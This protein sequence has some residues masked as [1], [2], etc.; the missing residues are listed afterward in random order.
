V[1]LLLFNKILYFK[2]MKF[3]PLI[4]A[5]FLA[6]SPGSVFAASDQV[7]EAEGTENS[8]SPIKEIMP[9][10][11]QYLTPAKKFLDT[12][13]RALKN[14]MNETLSDPGRPTTPKVSI[15]LPPPALKAPPTT[16]PMLVQPE[17][18][19]KEEQ[20]PA[21][22][23]PEPKAAVEPSTQT[24]VNEKVIEDVRAEVN[25]PKPVQEPVRKVSR[26]FLPGTP[27]PERPVQVAETQ[28]LIKPTPSP[29]PMPEP[30]VQV[31]KQEKPVPVLIPVT[32]P[33]ATTGLVL[34]QSMMLGS[35]FDGNSKRC[36]NKQNGYVLFCTRDI[37]WPEHIRKLFDNESTM[38][39]GAQA[40]V[41]YDGKKLTHA[42]ALFFTAGLK[43]IVSYTEKRFGSPL[44]TLQRIVTPF[45]G[46][47]MNNPT[48]IWRKNETVDGK[49]KA[50]TLEIRAF[51][52]SRGT[53]P[54]M[55]HG[56]VRLYDSESLPI[57]PRVSA[58]EMMLVN[59][60]LN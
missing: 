9:Y 39:R 49:M 56:L 28:D 13:A 35:L 41:R 30:V 11:R 43:E 17:E 57:F 29:A 42:H 60:A 36:I 4:L 51:D 1:I 52:D 5:L 34:G 19:P 3:I 26:K 22:P 33:V 20:A 12:E 46:R 14:W 8:D 23:E 53:F 15:D 50:I 16:T 54:D 25:A 55:E 7:E 27:K 18:A 38:H 44:E 37:I 47:P 10:V 58:T 45:E 21:T 48:L 2:I 40:I 6:L 24:V 32:V 31:T 59:H